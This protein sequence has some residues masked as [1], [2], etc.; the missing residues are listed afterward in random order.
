MPNVRT[1]LILLGASLLSGCLTLGQ[2]TLP[3]HK[4]MAPLGLCDSANDAEN[5]EVTFNVKQRPPLVLSTAKSPW[6]THLRY[7][8]PFGKTTQQFEVTVNN[9]GKHILGLSEAL[10]LEQ[11][12]AVLATPLPQAYFERLWPTGAVRNAEQLRDRSM[13][14]GE[15]IQSRW[16]ARVLYPG[17][18][19]TG[20]VIFDTELPDAKQPDT[21]LYLRVP[22]LKAE[23]V[24]NYT[25]C[26]NA[27]SSDKNAD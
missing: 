4:L 11:Q 20:R 27:Q 15:V 9:T 21:E 2:K 26:L 3:E 14:M 5:A 1:G 24:E 12:N 8:Y 22:L 23:R 6:D 19:Y 7:V 25:L 16:H 17:E 13:A 18:S 10:V